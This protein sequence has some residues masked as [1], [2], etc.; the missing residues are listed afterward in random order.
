MLNLLFLVV[1]VVVG[2]RSATIRRSAV[3]VVNLALLGLAIQAAAFSAVNWELSTNTSG[4]SKAWFQTFA[5]VG[6]VVAAVVFLAFLLISF[7]SSTSFSNRSLSLLSGASLAFMGIW[8]WS[9]SRIPWLNW[10]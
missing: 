8:F 4:E 2:Y 9:V 3:A 1:F 6:I 7:P 5:T 10:F